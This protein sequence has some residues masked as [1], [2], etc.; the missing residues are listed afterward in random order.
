MG[1]V[2]AEVSFMRYANNHNLKCL[3][4]LQ[5]YF[6]SFKCVATV[7]VCWTLCLDTSCVDSDGRLKLLPV[8]C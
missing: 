6:L 8:D 3:L 5:V 2:A 1:Y 7:I 4:R